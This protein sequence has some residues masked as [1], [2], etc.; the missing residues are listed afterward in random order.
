MS[1]DTRDRVPLDWAGSRFNLANALALLAERS[2]DRGTLEEAIACMR[3]AA[4]VYREGNVTYWLPVA[5]RRVG[6]ME[7]AL[8]AMPR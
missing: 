2:G 6:E 8:A 7:A 3:D 4:A 5:E 1:R